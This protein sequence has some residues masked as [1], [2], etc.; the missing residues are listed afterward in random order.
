MH[1]RQG[2]WPRAIELWEQAAHHQDLESHVELA[3]CYEHAL[4]DFTAARR[5]T[6][7]AITLLVEGM[8][9]APDGQPLGLYERRQRL[10]E[11]SHRLERLERKDQASP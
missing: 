10:A 1:K 6:Q 7:Q 8:A 4:R 5:W 3:K 9:T 11:L 2:D